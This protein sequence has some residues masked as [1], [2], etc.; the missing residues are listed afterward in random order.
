MADIYIPNWGTKDPNDVRTKSFDAA[1]VLYDEGNPNVTS[2]EV[3]VDGAFVLP[4][5]TLA[6]ADGLLVIT[7]VAWNATLK[8][9]SFTWSGGTSGK[10][11]VVTCRLSGA[12][13]SIDQ[14]A[15]VLIGQR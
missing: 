3:F 9:V 6:C 14:S 15:S 11:Y 1:G 8:R 5:G 2:C 4:D 12:G 13:F 7:N 10:I